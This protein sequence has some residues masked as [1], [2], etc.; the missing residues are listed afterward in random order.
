[1]LRS[2]ARKS[3]VSTGPLSSTPPQ[4]WIISPLMTLVIPTVACRP[5]MAT[6][7]S[8]GTQAVVTHTHT[9]QHTH[10]HTTT[11]H[12]HTHTHTRTRTRAHTHTHTHTHTDTRAM[13]CTYSQ[14]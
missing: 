2:C 10:T 1:T 8:A 11:R 13:L 4:V 6:A 3:Q 5:R 7:M 9:H 12:T 14:Y